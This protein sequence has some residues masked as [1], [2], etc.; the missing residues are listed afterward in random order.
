MRVFYHDKC[1]D[2]AAAAAVFT[3]F[4][5]AR[6]DAEAAFEY[7]GLVHKATGLFEGAEFNGD[8]NAIVDFKYNP[9]P[10]VT[11]WFDHHQSA[12]LQP[13]DGEHF[14][15]DRSG[16]KFYDPQYRSCTAFLA[17]IAHDRFGFDV[18]GLQELIHWA[19][20]VD[21]ALFASAAEAIA[22]GAPALQL[23]LAIEGSRDS[24]L[25]RQ[26]I[27]DF[28]HFSL[29]DLV[30]QP[31]VQTELAPLL[32]RHEQITAVLRERSECRDGVISFDL[33]DGD[34]EGYNKF[35]PYYWHP[36]GVY[37][38]GISLA[39]HRVKVSVGSNPWRSLPQMANLANICERYGGGGHPRVGAISFAPG[40]L[41][42]A[43]DVAGEVVEELRRSYRALQSATP[44]PASQA[45]RR[46]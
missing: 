23:T 19:D 32:A 18:S 40:D 4:Y 15:R 38:V 8:D 45:P 39:Q 5:R 46:A 33:S 21:G 31:Y 9:D 16:Q 27:P 2:G 41:K 29:A 35:A 36:D 22:L 26:L 37:S 30:R 44:L 43:R 28:L 42:T 24:E 7:C 11:W 13:A 12:F 20:V 25:A 3:A 1:F 14:R 17:Q 10:R 34:F 6:R